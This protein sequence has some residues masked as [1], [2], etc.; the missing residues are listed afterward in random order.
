MDNIDILIL[1]KADFSNVGYLFERA[2]K[3]VGIKAESWAVRPSPRGYG[4]HAN[5]FKD[6]QAQIVPRARQAKAIMLM[7]SRR[8]SAIDIRNKFVTVFHGGSRYR[9]AAEKMNAI[10]NPI[11]DISIIQTGDL[12]NL[13]AKNQVWILPCIDVQNIPHRPDQRDSTLS[14]CHYPHKGYIKGTAEIF[15]ILGRLQD[16]GIKCK[17]NS[18]NDR[19]KFYINES[20]VPWEDNIK[21]MSNADIYIEACEPDL[22]GHRYG[23]WGVT[24]LEAAAMGKIVITH[25]MSSQRYAKEYNTKCPF[26]VANNPK[27]FEIAVRKILDM[28]PEQV[29]H[30]RHISRAWVEKYHGFKAIGQRLKEKVYG[31]LF[32]NEVL[33]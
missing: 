3:E 2:L 1:A 16:E 30:T 33:E 9:G 19:W 5:L 21:R 11:V 14:F 31:R 18:R 28:S 27:E 8:F 32:T 23:E 7:H 22:R 12:L 25:F 20:V 29:E 24:A 6:L 10:F 17:S 26:F 4:K 13:G 15:R